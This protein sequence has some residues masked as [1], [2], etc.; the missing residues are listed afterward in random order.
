MSV[1]IIIRSK[2]QYNNVQGKA[3]QPNPQFA[4]CFPRSN[5]ICVIATKQNDWIEW[6]RRRKKLLSGYDLDDFWLN[7]KPIGF[8]MKQNTKM[9]MM[10][11]NTPNERIRFLDAV[12]LIVHI[13]H[14]PKNLQMRNACFCIHKSY[15]FL[16]VWVWCVCSFISSN[17]VYMRFP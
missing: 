9:G 3:R 17:Y 10:W 11:L 8:K 5:C 13:I 2:E 15:S 12:H 1:K 4:F 7:R 14:T 16:F 6:K